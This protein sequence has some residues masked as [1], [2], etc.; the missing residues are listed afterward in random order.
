MLAGLAIAILVVFVGLKSLAMLGLAL[1]SAVVSLA[2]AYIFLSRDVVHWP[3]LTVF[4][5][6]PIAAIVVYAFRNLLRVAI[7]SDAAWLLASATA[8][9]ALVGAERTGACPSTPPRPPRSDM[10]AISR[11]S[12]LASAQYP[13]MIQHPVDR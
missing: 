12:E 10:R 1:A 6:A 8:R 7:A 3:P 13:S 9:Q 5:L 11:S 2:A 4:I